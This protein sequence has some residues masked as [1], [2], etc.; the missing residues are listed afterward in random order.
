LLTFLGGVNVFLK[1][2]K[3]SKLSEGFDLFVGQDGVISSEGLVRFLR[4]MLT[5]V[6]AVTRA[7]GGDDVG[8]SNT[9]RNMIGA[10]S[11]W[12]AGLIEVREARESSSAER[13]TRSA[14]SA[15]RF[16]AGR[17][18]EQAIA[19]RIRRSEAPIVLS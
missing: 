13:I 19:S 16:R 18:F 1:G 12:T 4:G 3:S 14:F 8:V 5:A 11:I 17:L 7:G 6:V 9:V 10:G 2:R 15:A